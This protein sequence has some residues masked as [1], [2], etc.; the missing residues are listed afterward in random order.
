MTVCSARPVVAAN[1]NNYRR[2]RLPVAPLLV[3]LSLLALALTLLTLTPTAPVLAAPVVRNAAAALGLDRRGFTH[4]IKHA[5]HKAGGGLEK[6]LKTVEH[7]TPVTRG[8][9][10]LAKTGINAAKDIKDHKSIGTIAKD[11]GKGA[12]HSAKQSIPK[13]S[14]LK[15][16]KNVA[17]LTPAILKE[18]GR[19]AVSAAVDAVPAGG[20]AK[21]AI[22]AAK[23]VQKVANAR[24]R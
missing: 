15:A 24:Q 9:T 23:T 16:L 22:T 13:G 7:A 3:V 18:A 10:S 19:S 21:K 2:R 11:A 14:D 6:G 4:A 20:A 12:L 8:V 1:N 17:N 5:A